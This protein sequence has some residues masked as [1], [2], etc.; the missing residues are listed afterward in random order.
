MDKT[1]WNFSGSILLTWLA[2]SLKILL[3]LVNSSIIS[4]SKMMDW[5]QSI[6]KS[7]FG[8]C[9]W[10]FL[11]A[12]H[13][14]CTCSDHN[15]K[16]CCSPWQRTLSI[17][18]SY[19]LMFFVIWM[20]LGLSIF[21]HA[22][23]T[24]RSLNGLTGW[25]GLHLHGSRITMMHW[26]RIGLLEG[27]KVWKVSNTATRSMSTSACHWSSKTGTREQLKQ[28]MCPGKE[29]SVATLSSIWRL[30]RL[31]VL[32]W[33]NLHVHTVNFIAYWVILVILCNICTYSD[34]FIYA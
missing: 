13:G 3:S 30:H 22:Y 1:D 33:T 19:C 29:L 9:F 31:I 2:V 20:F 18:V 21:E 11:D 6:W 14:M 8:P 17:T 15:C 23:S 25:T 24:W 12:T 32:S 5:K 10:V 27:L 7:P 26:H 4:N 28:W 34:I 16:L